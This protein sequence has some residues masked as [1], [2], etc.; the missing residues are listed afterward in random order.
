MHCPPPV[1]G[2]GRRKTFIQHEEERR[3]DGGGKSADE[4]GWR[5]REPGD[6][7]PPEEPRRMKRLVMRAYAEDAISASRAS[8]LLGMTISEFCQIEEGQHGGFPIE[9]C[10]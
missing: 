7:I 2:A 1:K 8:E 9:M 3:G 6:Q 10:D 5:T 4:R